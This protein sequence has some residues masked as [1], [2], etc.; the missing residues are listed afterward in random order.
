MFVC[1]KCG[2]ILVSK[3]AF[4]YHMNR[5]RPCI[6][7]FSCECK[8]Q[9]KTK[10]DLYIHRI[11]CKESVHQPQTSE[12]EP[13]TCIVVIEGDSIKEIQVMERTFTEFQVKNLNV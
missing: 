12:P 11:N 13:D 6:E 3:Q 2:K 1:H 9:F 10:F 7:R 4:T 8:S 5:K